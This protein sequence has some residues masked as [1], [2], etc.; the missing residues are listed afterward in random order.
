VNIDRGGLA[1][2][3]LDGGQ[4]KITLPPG[5]GG[6]AED[7]LGNVILPHQAGDAVGNA[8]A[9]GA[10][11]FGAEILGEANVFGESLLIFG[12]RIAA[13]IDIKN[14]KVAA[15]GLGHAGAA[16]DQIL[17]RRIG[18]HADADALADSV[19]GLGGVF[20]QECVETAVYN[21][22][23]LAKRQLA[24]SNQI[25][26][27]EKVRKGTLGAIYGIDVA[28]LHA[29]LQGLRSQIGE[30]NFIHPLHDPVRDSF[31]DLD[32]GDLL[33][34][35]ADALHVLHVHGREH[36]NFGVEEFDD[37]LVAL[38]MLAALDVG[39]SQLIDDRDAW[40]AGQNGVDIHFVKN[41]ALVFEFA[42]RN[43]LQ[44]AHQFRGGLA[45]V[46]F[47]HADDHILA[48]AGAANRLAEHVV[49]LADSRSVA[50]EQLENAAR[51][52]R[53][54]VL[55]PLFGGLSHR[56]YCACTSGKMSR[57]TMRVVK[58]RAQ[59]QAVRYVVV[60][61][62]IGAVTAAGYRLHVNQTTVALMFLV[63]VLLTSAYWG[64]R[65]AVAFAVGATAAFN[66][67]F[68]PPVGTFTIAD[69]QNWVA[70]FAFLITALVASNLAERARREAEGAQQRRREVERLY[71][72]SQRLLASDNV[73][74][75]LNA[76]PKYVQETFSVGSVVAMAADHPT[77]YRSSLDAPFEESVLRST[78]L[79]GEPIT[80][81]G[82]SY[83]P[84]RLGMRTVGALGIAGADLPRAT[85]DALGSLTGLAVE[86][87]RALEA[88]S[89]NRAEQEHERLRT[90]LLDS[91]THEFR[92]PLT[93]I[94]ASVTTLLSG[95]GLDD[96]GRH[97]LLAVID[98]ET[99]RLN[100]LV[101]EASEMA[102][103]DSGMFK[104]DLQPHAIADALAP[105]LEDARGA[106][107][108]HP[109]EVAVAAD[110]PHVSMD[111]QRIR[112]V[113]MHLLENAGKY[114]PAGSPIKIT[115]EVQDHRL[116][117]SIADRG[118][119]IDSFE[120]SLIFEKFYRG[121]N[122]RYMAPGTGM[123]LAIAKVI[124]EAHGGKIGVVSQLG[125]GSVFSF[126]LPI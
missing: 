47:D 78:L 6:T 17:G 76:L 48:A 61:V 45:A 124:V 118:P 36:I 105:A 24:Q 35:G 90:A 102:Q 1:K 88:L 113:L 120:Q 65:Y 60:A 40:L 86:R 14:V 67:F 107:E 4:V 51:L 80:Q 123:G 72:L 32:A 58:T 66:F 27:T 39:V 125:S 116:V 29:F 16:R 114:S 94:K 89:K 2:E 96:S 83:V 26:G 21:P 77:V 7:H 25:A 5:A 101:G 97:D 22:S 11:H 121:Q 103:L 53:R 87:A 79:R 28:A 92:T 44:L 71:G 75:L 84:V 91:V 31:A 54:N 23:H 104:L 49:G 38:G 81:K 42:G 41:R 85:L 100:R 99:D 126:S 73:L 106:L 64:L 98:E 111:V 70:L 10:N 52:F 109:V 112:E 115:S 59:T 57:C 9:R 3:T 34:G 37:V 122:Q 50:E 119:G 68:L 8:A 18:A 33:D 19:R 15:D 74:E 43:A 62:A 82:V 95:A 12:T 46:S 69:P 13:D 63:L 55:E 30:D 20:F 110:L 56:S 108:N 117:T 93:S